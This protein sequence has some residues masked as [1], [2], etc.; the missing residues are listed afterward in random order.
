MTEPAADVTV[1]MSVTVCPA[2][3]EAELACSAVVL[4]AVIVPVW[5]DCTV[6][7][8]PPLLLAVSANAIE[9]PTSEL[10]GVYVAPVAPGIAE[11]PSALQRSHW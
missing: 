9:S 10:V 4:G 6:A 8:V 3:G 5:A 11:H 7:L 1:A 2:A